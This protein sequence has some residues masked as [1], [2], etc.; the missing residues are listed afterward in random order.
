MATTNP[1]KRIVK[2]AR[3]AGVL[4]PRDL[5][6]EGIARQYLRVAADKGLIIR[7]ARGLYTA[8]DA[9]VTEF[10]SL[11]QVAKKVPNGV[12]CLLSA[13]SYHGIGTQNPYQVWLAIGAKDRR[14]AGT[15]P[16]LR[17]ARFSKRALEFGQEIH[18]IEGVSV[19]VFSIAKTVAD[20]FKFRNKIGLDVAL[21]ALRASLGSK[22]ATPSQI[23][24]AAMV[25][26]VAN[27]IRPYMEALV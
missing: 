10:H 21:E 14:P 13:L 6:S 3:T 26:R 19:R 22:E 7:S 15:N 5:A 20:C 9:P 12:I 27:V 25:C 2:L 1:I 17:I 16:Q 11:A 4:R 24:E 18:D 8:A 23:W